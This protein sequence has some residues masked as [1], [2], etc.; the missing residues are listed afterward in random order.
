MTERVASGEIHIGIDNAASAGLRKVEAEFEKTMASI[1]RK[2]ATAN[3]TANTKDLD[4][5]I[6]LAKAKLE[7]LEDAHVNLSGAQK[8][9]STKR[10]NALKKELEAQQKNLK[11][12]KERLEWAKRSN[13][14]HAFTEQRLA[15]EAKLHKELQRVRERADREHAK[16]LRDQERLMD[17]NERARNREMDAAQRQA[18]AV[19]KE[20]NSV[21][22]LDR[23]YMALQERLEKLAE[24]RRK[25]RG[26]ERATFKVDV[27]E[28]M[29]LAEMERLRREVWAIAHRD[30]IS[31]PVKPEL[32]ARWA[33]VLRREFDAVASEEGVLG[34][35]VFQTGRRVGRLFG[36]RIAAGTRDTLDRGLSNVLLD[37]GTAASARFGQALLRGVSRVGHAAGRLSDMTIRL[38][39][40]T[41]SIKSAVA[42]LSL[43]APVLIDIT[44][45]LGA[46]IG[47]AGAAVAGASALGIGIAGGAIPA[48]IGMGIVIK[49][50]AG[51]FADVMKAQKAYDDAIQKGN[52][53][54]AKDKMKEMQA[55]MGNV[56]K[57]TV[58]QIGHASKLS[59][60]WNKAT[61]P[62][63]AAVFTTIGEG[64]KTAS[65]L[66]PMFAKNTNEAMEEASTGV[67][68]WMEALRSSEGRAV[69]DTMM[70]NFTRSLGP[71]L[72]GMGNLLGYLGRVGAIASDHL[73]DLARTFRDWAEGLNSVSTDDLEDKVDGVVESAKNMG[74][75]FLEAGRL[76]KTFFG[77]GVEAGDSFVETM[78]NAM[79]TWREGFQ[80]EKGHDDLTDFFHESVEGAKAFWNALVPVVSS[81]TR[82]AQ[83]MAPW[84]RHFF[85]AAA[86]V[87]ELVS[88]FLDL[89]G[90]RSP[91]AALVTTLGTLWAIGKISTATM[92]VANF[93]R[94]LGGLGR[95]QAG[96]AGAA[97]GGAIPAYLIPAGAVAGVDRATGSVT[98]L[99]RAGTIASR[100]LSGIGA[101]L[102]GWGNPWV[103][104][105]ILGG[106]LAF[107]L[108]KVIDTTDDWEES[109]AAS[110]EAARKAD[111]SARRL[112]ESYGP[113][114]QQATAVKDANRTVAEAQ[115]EV[116]RLLDDGKR[117]TD[118]YRTAVQ[119]LNDEILA[120]DQAQAQQSRDLRKQNRTLVQNLEDFTT[121]LHEAKEQRDQVADEP[122]SLMDSDQIAEDVDAFEDSMMTVE[123]AFKIV[124]TEAKDSGQTLEKYLA[125]LDINEEFKDRLL[126]Y[127]DALGKI[128][129]A[130]RGLKGQAFAVAN[131]ARE[132]KGMY[133]MAEKAALAVDYL[134]RKLGAKKTQQISLKFRGA[135]DATRVAQSAARSLRAG[136]PK[137]VTT[138][139]VANSSNADAAVRALQRAQLTPK[140]LEIIETGGKE[141]IR[142]LE[143]IMGRKLT[144]QELKIVENGGDHVLDKLRDIE[145]NAKSL[146]T[147]ETVAEIK[148]DGTVKSVLLGIAKAALGMPTAHADV[149]TNGDVAKDV[150]D[151]IKTAQDAI[152][153][154]INIAVNVT[155]DTIPAQA[156]QA[157]GRR[158]ST[159]QHAIVGEGS[160][161]K[162]ARE[163]VVNTRTGRVTTVDQTTPMMLEPTDA[164]IPTEPKYRDR[165]RSIFNEI[166]R[167]KQV[168][169]AS[170]AMS[171]VA[172]DLGIG[173]FAAGVDPVY[174]DQI[175]S[176]DYVKSHPQ[177]RKALNAIDLMSAGGEFPKARQV[178]NKLP[179]STRWR[180]QSRMQAVLPRGWALDETTQK[181]VHVGTAY[182]KGKL[183]TLPNYGGTQPNTGFSP[184]AIGDRTPTFNPV[185]KKN[186]NF[187]AKTN[188]IW[189]GY[190][191]NLQQQQGYWEREVS[192]K[193]SEVKPPEDFVIRG[194]DKQIGTNPDGTPITVET[195]EPNPQINA[196]KAQL[197]EVLNAMDQ[198]IRIIV[199][200]VRAIPQAIAANQWEV[201]ERTK[202]LSPKGALK[203]ALKN[204]TDKKPKNQ[205]Q[206]FIGK[207]KD[208][209]AKHE[210]AKQDLLEDQGLLKEAQVEG[211]FAFREA[212]IARADVQEEYNT[213]WE[214]AEADAAEQNAQELENGGGGSGGGGGGSSVG[215]LS[216]GQQAALADTEKASVLREFGSNFSANPWGGGGAGMNAL[217]NVAQA[218]GA[219]ASEALTSAGGT[220]A[221]TDS[222]SG[223]AVLDTRAAGVAVGSAQAAAGAI[224]G[225][226]QAAAGASA[227]PAPQPA[228]TNNVTVNNTFAT[229]P[230]DPHTFARGVEFEIAAVV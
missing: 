172:K 131:I 159:A 34:R 133:P 134:N 107:A 190:I 98:K 101:A 206:K 55:I 113:L 76:V 89:T 147:A 122:V 208:D 155:G 205:N 23:Q 213:A 223:A 5:E 124:K 204:Q 199:E 108:S 63:R 91:I 185:K 176:G 230:P 227:A 132:F 79:R 218:A 99:G 186:L 210:Q 217:A 30:P 215:G 40:F 37:A 115:R 219:G 53:D 156:R 143:D 49:K 139:L 75:F 73:P 46:F 189:A 138:R 51:E 203:T 157:S 42:G 6:A 152:D 9:A 43:L 58:R 151:S 150:L 27:E 3:I 173:T 84:A 165:G 24:I 100:G 120:R 85:D 50:V 178:W 70:D 144:K 80:T 72:D 90:L 171:A 59:D 142:V 95:A 17:R 118:E 36:A 38:G 154:A 22:K 222:M 226:T 83:L 130:E 81:F 65:D 158:S 68:K 117:G 127:G 64:I 112:A 74:R 62:A 31:L 216:Y 71:A 129:D 104:A 102:T 168:L 47:S 126:G 169:A 145:G 211:G 207:L 82:W 202:L 123:E 25:A 8:G 16:A 140:R 220:Q 181:L 105:A 200:L 191:K 111:A 12:E 14:Q 97:R 110:D 93:V 86:A 57:E 4:K 20:R 67:N 162:G 92:A 77:A 26:D 195:Y 69:L 146:P 194:P 174:G 148:G 13:E 54:L 177:V 1:A 164:V 88:E 32:G 106:G 136:V 78:T 60:A 119:R 225:A 48:F 94:A 141:A 44:G 187:K 193:E 18:I 41:T 10:I 35:A 160:D 197:Q 2:E 61:Q 45:A 103:G 175:P 209:I 7:E 166:T 179:R 21:A 183:P 188:N 198:L 109:M 121:Q 153:R 19:E 66:M 170:S 116:N 29:A 184:E 182:A 137:S 192:I 201:A 180:Y 228:P 224:S 167:G 56:S 163:H 114:A 52:T 128:G 221:R 212:K 33:T 135:E 28:R 229:V 214:D 96:I 161:W 39:P 11:V 125:G 196:Y 87:G 15:A 149:T